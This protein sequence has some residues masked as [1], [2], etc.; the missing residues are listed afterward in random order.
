[1]KGAE[2]RVSV[3]GESVLSSVPVKENGS[4]RDIRDALYSKQAYL[5]QRVLSSRAKSSGSDMFPG[6]S[7]LSE[8]DKFL[9]LSNLKIDGFNREIIKREMIVIMKDGRILEDSAEIEGIFTNN[10]IDVEVGFATEEA[11]EEPVPEKTLEMADPMGR[12]AAS[13]EKENFS[14]SEVGNVQKTLMESDQQELAGRRKSAKQ[15]NSPRESRDSEYV[16]VRCNNDK[17]V[18]VKKKDLVS[19]E[20]KTYLINKKK[21]LS[22][23][24]I[25][26][27]ITLS[28]TIATYLVAGIL[29]TFYLNRI[30]FAVFLVIFFLKLMGKTRIF[31]VVNPKNR[32]D[33]LLKNV[34]CFFLSFFMNFGYNLNV[35][36]DSQ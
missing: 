32:W 25:A 5:L 3:K 35:K 21:K 12:P 30:V 29:L 18:M 15:G 16:R 19:I 9:Y 4:V 7:R 24:R 31:I 11:G 23:P 1:M 8:E 14:F 10:L 13:G 26:S 17:T 6:F 2:L 36:L 27:H 20:G 22:L 33:F 34:A 28:T